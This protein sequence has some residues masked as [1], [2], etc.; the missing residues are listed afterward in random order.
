M[1]NLTM[2]LA[3]KE[4]NPLAIFT[5]SNIDTLI[6]DIESEARSMVFDV[7][8]SK[9]R[10]EIASLAYEVSRSKSALDG[11]GKKLVTEWKTKSKAVDVERKMMRDRLDALRNEVR[12]PLSDWEEIEKK[13]VEMEALQKEINQSWLLA[14]SENELFDR[15]KEAQKKEKELIDRENA[16]AKKAEEERQEKIRAEREEEIARKASAKSKAEAEEK[17]KLEQRKAEDLKQQAIVKER[18]HKEKILAEKERRLFEVK[19]AEE[20]VRRELKEDHEK[21]EAEANKRASDVKHKSA[22]NRGVLTLF[23]DTGLS[24][25]LSKKLIIRIA[26][27]EIPNLKIIY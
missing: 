22:V 8:T 12:K 21:R 1:N 2:D 4:E 23:V 26:K 17:I 24:V 27:N 18:E 11:L 19:E 14:L 15:E 3:Q 10:K 6:S 7:S 16:I 20:K 9:G 5:T 25:E 13:R